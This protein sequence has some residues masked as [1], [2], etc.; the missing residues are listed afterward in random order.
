L[1]RLRTTLDDAA[2]VT[3]RIVRRRKR[4]SASMS[5]AQFDH[6][7]WYAKELTEFAT[8]LGIPSA[9]K[10]RKDQLESSI[11]RFLRSGTIVPSAKP[12]QKAK[13]RSRP[14]DVDLGLRLDRRVV[15]Y[16]NDVIT[17]GFLE[18]EALKL[19]PTFRSRSGAKYRLNRWREEQI[20]N[21]IELTYRDVVA[22]YVRLAQ[23][24]A[25]FARIPHGRYINFV[26]EFL[27]RQPGATRAAAIQAWRNLKKMDC[28]KTYGDWDAAGRR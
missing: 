8:E 9:G 25:R 26:S 10:L 14:R 17:K 19:A 1:D 4:L 12:N 21:G 5:V 22:E 24:A 28:P 7:Y 16:T 13:P 3:V 6:G 15:R 23:S 11:K 2:R 27:T 20:Q 18:R